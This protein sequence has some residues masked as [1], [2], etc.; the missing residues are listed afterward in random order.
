MPPLQGDR[1][2]SSRQIFYVSRYKP[3][4]P[5]LR[6]R[7]IASRGALADRLLSGGFGSCRLAP[8]QP[9]PVKRAY[10]LSLLGAPDFGATE[11]ALTAEPNGSILESGVGSLPWSRS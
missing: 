11:G 10:T 9:R 6:P 5:A 1:R 7:L 3:N 4:V 8:E 2:T